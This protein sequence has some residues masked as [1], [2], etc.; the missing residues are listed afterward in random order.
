MN[1][2]FGV[3]VKEAG[4][5]IGSMPHPNF[6]KC[7]SPRVPVKFTYSVSRHRYFNAAECIEWV[8]S[9]VISAWRSRR[10]DSKPTQ[11]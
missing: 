1:I 10:G 5:R 7:I 3:R 2:T 6:V 11:R 8:E 9:L 4:G